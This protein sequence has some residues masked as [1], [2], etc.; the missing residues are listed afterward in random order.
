MQ[1]SRANRRQFYFGSGDRHRLT[2]IYSTLLS[3][4]CLYTFYLLIQLMNRSRVL[5]KILVSM[6]RII[7]LAIFNEREARRG[8]IAQRL[9]GFFRPKI[10]SQYPPQNYCIFTLTPFIHPIYSNR[11][12]GQCPICS[13]LM[14]N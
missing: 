3:T 1:F 12:I 6:V 4:L 11:G 9:F 8:Q 2:G 7:A 14:C 10:N 5:L 13:Q